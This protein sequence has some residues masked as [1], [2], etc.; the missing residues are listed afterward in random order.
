G[1]AGA[2]PELPLAAG[3]RGGDARAD[4]PPSRGGAGVSDGTPTAFPAPVATGE[5]VGGRRL[6]L[7]GRVLTDG[8]ELPPSRVEIM[9]GRIAGVQPAASPAGA[10]LVVANGWIVPGLIDLQVNGAGGVDLTSATDLANAVGAVARTL[11]AHGV[12]AFCPTIVSAPP[13]AIVE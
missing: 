1:Q 9:D 13:E 11:A 5:G 10:D 3:A 6:T 12:T 7:F 4:D 2:R 8:R